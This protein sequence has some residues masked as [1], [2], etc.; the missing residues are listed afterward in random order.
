M[1]TSIDE[2]YMFIQEWN[3]ILA[4]RAQ[5]EASE[6]SP[7]SSTAADRA[8][9]LPGLTWIGVNRLRNATG[10]SSDAVECWFNGKQDCK[11][12]QRN[13]VHHVRC[14]CKMLL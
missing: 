8:N 4:A 5:A 10:L 2:R 14:T 13:Q 11:I 1:Q 12:E 6:C 7:I 9:I 3:S